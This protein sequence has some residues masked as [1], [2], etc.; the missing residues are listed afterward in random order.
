MSKACRRDEEE[1]KLPPIS[2]MQS[3]AAR[4]GMV[5]AREAAQQGVVKAGSAAQRDEFV[6][7]SAFFFFPEERQ[8]DVNVH[9]VGASAS[10]RALN[11]WSSAR[12]GSDGAVY[13]DADAPGHGQG[14]RRQRL[15]GWALDKEGRAR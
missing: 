4:R 5:K 1:D 15:M 2:T 12:W 11:V 9:C 8:T 13:K 3:E 14:G 10:N 6:E 7:V